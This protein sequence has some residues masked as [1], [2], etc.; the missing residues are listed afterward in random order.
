MRAEMIL[1]ED[2]LILLL[3]IFAGL[4][5]AQAFGLNTFRK[6]ALVLYITSV[7]VMFV[8]KICFP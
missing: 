6:I 4:A 5:T 2:V 8:I 7:C 1:S 3:A